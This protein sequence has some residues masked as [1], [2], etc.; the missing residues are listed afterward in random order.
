MML[1]TSEAWSTIRLSHRQSD[2]SLLYCKLTDFMI[3]YHFW[4]KSNP[5]ILKMIRDICCILKLL[6]FCE[7]K[8]SY[9]KIFWGI[10]PHSVF[11]KFKDWN[12]KQLLCLVK[13][14]YIWIIFLIICNAK[15]HS[16]FWTK[17][18]NYCHSVWRESLKSTLLAAGPGFVLPYYTRVPRAEVFLVVAVTYKVQWKWQMMILYKLVFLYIEII[19]KWFLEGF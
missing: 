8:M 10:I 1:G 6:R 17:F 5:R 19:S 15:M 14:T 2:P 4:N 11:I 13:S 3:H 9:L 7:G 12:L 18:E 16:N